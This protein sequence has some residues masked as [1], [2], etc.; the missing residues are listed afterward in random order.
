MERIFRMFAA[1]WWPQRPANTRAASGARSAVCAHRE[2]LIGAPLDRVFELVGDI[3]WL[4]G[5]NPYLETRKVSGPFDRVGTS[6]DAT[7]RLLGLE[8]AGRGTVVEAEPRRLVHLRVACT[9]RGGTGDW[10]YTLDPIDGGTRCSIAIECEAS[11]TLL[12]L[13]HLFGRSA[14]QTALERTVQQLLDN[15]ASLAEPKVPQPA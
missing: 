9:E 7:V 3:E 13:E 12:A 5:W 6:F 8:F 14:V 2:R 15:L 4:P 1:T 10:I 11:G